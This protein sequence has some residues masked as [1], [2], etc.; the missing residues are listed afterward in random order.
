MSDAPRFPNMPFEVMQ[1]HFAGLLIV[2]MQLMNRLNL[3][4]IE[5]DLTEIPDRE[6]LQMSMNDDCSKMMLFLDDAE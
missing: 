4:H 6:N 3:D 2:V 5:T 1:V